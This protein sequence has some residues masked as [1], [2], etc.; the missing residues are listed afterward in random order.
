[1]ASPR[2]GVHVFFADDV[3]AQTLIIGMFAAL[4]VD[5]SGTLTQA[6]LLTARSSMVA[7]FGSD[8]DF[9]AAENDKNN[10]GL[11]DVGEWTEFCEG[12]YSVMGRKAF[13]TAC[14][15]WVLSVVV[16]APPSAAGK[17]DAAD[18][19]D[20]KKKEKEEEEKAA[21]K[22][23]S[24]QRGKK[25]RKEAA[26]KKESKAKANANDNKTE[27]SFTLADFW[28]WLMVGQGISSLSAG[29][30]VNLFADC[31]EFGLNMTLAQYIPMHFEEMVTPED[32]SPGEV[33]LLC[34]LVIANSELTEAA[35]REAL[36]QAR[37]C[38]DV[39]EHDKKTYAKLE[40]AINLRRFKKLVSL[41][42]VLMRIDEEYVALQMQWCHTEVF[43]TTDTCAAFIIERCAGKPEPGTEDSLPDENVVA[44]KFL[45]Q[46]F[47][48]MF[49]NCDIMDD[50][51]KNGVPYGDISLIYSRAVKALPKRLEVRAERRKQKVNKSAKTACKDS[52]IK[53]R[54]EFEV[55]MEELN[56]LAS[57]KKLFN[58]PLLMMSGLAK[59]ARD[60]AEN[61]PEKR[62]SK[63]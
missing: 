48:S 39:E 11:V 47:T 33:A 51:G 1:M 28:D 13:L 27:K 24:I 12:L 15:A 26:G 52:V 32:L 19:V 20:Q 43:E 40:G 16:K 6:E 50:T 31:K 22:I 61:G 36:P 18:D 37:A 34:K 29:D 17:K 21:L 63:C 4:D 41:I 45:L 2:G 42:S 35:A 54:T 58:T 7:R 8:L 59:R 14:R 25:A 56:S 23:Q 3:E 57:M 5:S 55:L 38:R 9:C 44:K 30:V 62:A 49:Y 60:T 53:G 10:D 46:L